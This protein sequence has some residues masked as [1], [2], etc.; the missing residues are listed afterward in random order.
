MNKDTFPSGP[1]IG[2]YNYNFGRQEKHR[3]DL[4]L[5]FANGSM[6]GQGSDDVGRF[7]IK[8]RYNPA[9]KECYWTE[10]YIGAHEVFYRGF[11]DGKG[12]WGTWEIGPHWRGGFHV[13]PRQAGEWEEATVSAEAEAPVDAI[14]AEAGVVR[15]SIGRL[16]SP[17]PLPSPQGGGVT[18][19]RAESPK[20]ERSDEDG[21]MFPLCLGRGGTQKIC[22]KNYF[23]NEATRFEATARISE[24]ERNCESVSENESRSGESA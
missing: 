24:K 18:L 23:S 10:S 17:S 5:T 15:R 16:R 7:L 9:N 8:G 3:M 22:E 11:R 19:P 14:A 13:W 12:I 2:F 20:R 21:R 6:T 4:N 1:W